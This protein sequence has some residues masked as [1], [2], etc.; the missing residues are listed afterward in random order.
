MSNEF[1]PRKAE[2]HSVKLKMAIQGPSGSGKTEGALALATNFVPNAKILVIDTENDS[3]SLYADRYNFD[4][5]SL[6]APYTSERY[7]KAMQVAGQ[8]GYDVLIVDSLTQQWDGE[9]GILRR[10]EQLDRQPGSNS[11]TNWS[12][13]TPEHT[14][15]VEFI[16]QLPIHTICTMRTKQ[17]YVLETNAKGKQQP[18]KVGTAPIQR[19]GLE[20]EFTVVFDV[21][22]A[23]RAT[24]SK[25]RT[26]LFNDDEPIDLASPEVAGAIRDWLA[27]GLP[28]EFADSIQVQKLWDMCA[29]SGKTKEEIKAKFDEAKIP[30]VKHITLDWYEVLIEWARESTAHAITNV[31]GVEVTDDDVPF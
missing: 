8:N 26:T 7:K 24:A 12:T 29:S 31:H 1:T 5:I 3:A 16:K 21:N 17:E 13:F 28:P 11:Y 19:D 18:R 9:D 20:Y 2:K 15:F 6:T 4:T 22:M 14:A 23:H 27:N 30:S 25:N 10:K